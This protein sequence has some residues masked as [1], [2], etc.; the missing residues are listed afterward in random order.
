MQFI[1]SKEYVRKD[2]YWGPYVPVKIGKNHIKID[3]YAD[4][5]SDIILLPYSLIEARN[6][7]LGTPVSFRQPLGI[8]ADGRTVYG[9]LYVNVPVE[10][11]GQSFITE[12]AVYIEAEEGE[13]EPLLGRIILDN[14]K[15]CFDG[16]E[17]LLSFFD[18]PKLLARRR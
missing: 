17:K 9:L 12:V 4:T 5:G 14:F 8:T 15:V 2:F 16:K 1:F 18:P 6:I 10:L 3:A 13:T 7:D 11:G